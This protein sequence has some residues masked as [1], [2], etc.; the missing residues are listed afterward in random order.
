MRKTFK[1]KD[2]SDEEAIGWEGEELI[3]PS[4]TL[5]LSMLCC[6]VFDDQDVDFVK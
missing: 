1:V 3:S 6:E 2:V 5:A 4:R